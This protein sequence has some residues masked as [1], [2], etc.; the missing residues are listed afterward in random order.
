MGPPKAVDSLCFGPASGRY[1][2]V[3]DGPPGTRTLNS[4][5]VCG[6]GGSVGTGQDERIAPWRI[7]D[8]QGLLSSVKTKACLGDRKQGAHPE[9]AQAKR[10]RVSSDPVERGQEKG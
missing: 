6:P 7:Q 9:Q 1:H 3:T 10:E 4:L 5:S 2:F 8:G